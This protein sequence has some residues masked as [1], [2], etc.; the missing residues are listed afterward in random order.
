MFFLTHKE[1]DQCNKL[2]LA[3]LLS[4]QV[5]INTDRRY[6]KKMWVYYLLTI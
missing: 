2:I 3:S 1:T 4:E 5:L 6:C